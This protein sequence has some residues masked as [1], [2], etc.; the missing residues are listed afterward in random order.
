MGRQFNTTISAGASFDS[1]RLTIYH[2][3]FPAIPLQVELF[4]GIA[5][6]FTLGERKPGEFDVLHEVGG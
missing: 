5:A 3:I 1:N 2:N 6:R 4:R